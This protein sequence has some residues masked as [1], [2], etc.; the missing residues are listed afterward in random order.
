MRVMVG[1]GVGED[2]VRFGEA[3]SSSKECA[4]GGSYS[5]ETSLTEPVIV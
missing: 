2:D 5:S 1:A 4:C 3:S